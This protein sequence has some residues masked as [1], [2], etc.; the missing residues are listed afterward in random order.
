MAA[1]AARGADAV[2]IFADQ[3]MSEGGDAPTLALPGNQNAL[4]A[5]VAKANPHTLVILETGNPVSMPWID[6]VQGVLEA[7][8][9]GIGGGQAIANVLFGSVDPSGKLPITF[10]RSEKDLP[11]P[12]IFGMTYKT[13]A[14]GGLPEHWVSEEKTASFPAD[15]TEGVRF[16]Y[17][18][19]ESEQK[20]PLFPFGFGLSYTHFTYDDLQIDSDKKQVHFRVRNDGQ[21]SGTEVAQAYVQ[22]PPSSGEK[23]MRLA[24]WG[25]V[26]LAPGASHQVTVQLEP[27]ALASWNEPAEKWDWTHGDYT[28][29]VGRSS[30]DIALS[31]HLRM[32]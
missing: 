17:K 22:L 8:Y 4:I 27:L 21:R 26:T 31:G 5:A 24:G 1:Q 23:F 32:Q 6:D 9:P 13:P 29:K 3:Y 12:R 10:P 18:W 16:G 2:L 15:Y 14:N 7:W 11:H 28:V 30:A 20:Q 19:F 25:R